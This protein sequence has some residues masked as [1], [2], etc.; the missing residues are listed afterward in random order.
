MDPLSVVEERVGVVETWQTYIIR[1]VFV[2]EP[3]A[4]TVK[5]MA[6][7]FYGNEVSLHDAVKGVNACNG[8]NHRYVTEKMYEWY[9]V[10]RFHTNRRHMSE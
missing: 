7:F 6:G 2:D 3:D 4:R 8:G 1:H 10:W 9:Y 5:T